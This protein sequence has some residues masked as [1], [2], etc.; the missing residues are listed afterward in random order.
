MKKSLLALPL[1]AGAAWA[2][3]TYYSGAQTE[4]AYTR[5]LEQLNNSSNNAFVLKST[6]YNAG[7]MESTAITEV[8]SSEASGEDI[9]FFLKHQIN[10][11]LVSVAPENPRFGAASIITT[12]LVDESYSDDAKEFMKSFETGEPF[13]ATT[14]VSV[15][16]ATTSEIKINAVDHSADDTIVK[17]SGS[18]INVVTTADGNVTGDGTADN[19]MFSEGTDKK[20]DMSN[21]TMKFDMNKLKGE[22]TASA[23][24]RDLNFELKMDESKI[25][26]GGKQVALIEGISYVLNQDL[27]SDEPSANFSMGVDSLEIE[28]VPLKSAD[29]AVALTGFSIKDLIANETF[30][31]EFKTASKPEELIFS[32][33]GLELLRATFKPDTKMAIKLDATSTEGDGNAAVDLWFSGNGSDDG[34]TGMATA[35][36]LAKS[37]AGTAVVDVDRAAIMMTPLGGMLEHPMAQAYLTVTE[38]KVSLNANLDKLVLKL[39]EQVIP[40]ELM[41]GDMLNMPLE[42][43]LK[44]M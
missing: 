24:F 10:H 19:F 38:D 15:D 1:V 9:H 26:D 42:D 18:V 37:I 23:Y 36:D 16:G 2:G 5:L 41:A 27:S 14:E 43:L 3:S 33:Q 34:Y 4:A 25:V 7:T 32:G 28:A 29:V 17:S 40:L 12:L 20:A 35:G 44:Q 22:E 39:N 21:L 8:R 11:S 13:V 6:E 31:E 30:F